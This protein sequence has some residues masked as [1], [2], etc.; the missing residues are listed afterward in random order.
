MGLINSGATYQIIIEQIMA[1]VQHE[2]CLIYLDNVI[3]YS[4]TFD[5]DIQRLDEVFTRM[6]GASLKFSPAKCNL[7]QQ[8]VTFLG[9]PVSTLGV[10]TCKDKVQAVQNLPL[11]TFLGLASYYRK[12]IQSFSSITDPLNKLP[13]KV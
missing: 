12:F 1:G 11:P 2:T 8:E 6:S 7:T 9:H 5:D 3:V 13:K 4:K 10:A